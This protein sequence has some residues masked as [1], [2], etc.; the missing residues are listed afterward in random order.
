MAI[1]SI[2][3]IQHRRGL[4]ADLPTNLADGELGFCIDTR[5]LFV[6]NSPAY[7]NNTEIVTQWSNNDE[8]IQHSYNGSTGTP[9]QTGDTPGSPVL[10]PLGQ[11]LDDIVSIKDYGAIG[12]GVTDDTA[13]I[14][15]AMHDRYMVP[16][17]SGRSPLTSR[18][19][20]Y[21]PAGRYVV[22]RTILLPPYANLVGDGK[23]HTEIYMDSSLALV[24][25]LPVLGTSD[26]LGNSG[27]MIGNGTGS[28]APTYLSLTG[29][30]ITHTYAN[31][32]VFRA[33]RVDHLKLEDV[34]LV[35]PWHTGQG[36]SYNTAALR[37]M[38]HGN[39]HPVNHL[40]AS[41]CQFSHTAYG[42]AMYDDSDV[43]NYATFVGCEFSNCFNGVV[44]HAGFGLSSIA[45]STFINL[46]DIGLILHGSNGVVSSN[47]RYQAVAILSG[48]YGVTWD[49]NTQNCGSIA[50]VFSMPLALA[51][52]DGHPGFNVILNS[53]NSNNTGGLTVFGPILLSYGVA[54]N[55]SVL[56]Y[57]LSQVTAIV[58][59]YSMTR[60]TLRR[61]GQLR[62]ISDGTTASIVDSA[63]DLG[64][65]L[66]IS[67]GYT[68][69]GSAPSILTLTYTTTALPANNIFMKYT[70][71]SWL[72]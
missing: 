14:E 42:V 10:R 33:S 39:I 30:T 47:N 41:N 15:R 6:G 8:L 11:V 57:D 9:A 45:S 25:A 50:D 1:T 21:F 66:G 29:I 17:I 67:W 55:P 27:Y 3:R 19:R 61:I 24:P 60:G 20:I 7:G 49:I 34:A 48:S 18:V 58:M 70:I 37:L 53:I 13:A 5:E 69:T 38:S 35:G 56:Q 65:S 40:Y 31:A 32:D 12:D 26:N 43:V 59:D 22:S 52:Y 63:S 44:G 28:I 71:T 54:A 46:D 62:I 2:S 36:V 16:V 23:S 68:I 51:V 72:A 4:K 64:A